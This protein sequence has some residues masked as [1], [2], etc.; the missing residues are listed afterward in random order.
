[1][2]TIERLSFPVRFAVMMGFMAVVLL[3]M[4]GKA[5]W[6]RAQSVAIVLETAPVDPRSMFQGDYV[7]LSYKIGNLASSVAADDGE[8]IY[9]VLAQDENGLWQ[10][11][12][13]SSTWPEDLQPD[14]RV[15]RGTVQNSRIIYGIEAF[16][17][18]EGHG[19]WIEQIRDRS[20]VTVRVLIDPEGHAQMDALLIDG[21]EV[22]APTGL[23]H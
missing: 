23:V 11:V 6:Q 22:F 21:Q 16:F 15:I 14:Q 20:R 17:V 8:T 3:G 9:T 4:I 12:R 18:P 5:E 10:A 13:T 2:M 1:M 19:R 7:T